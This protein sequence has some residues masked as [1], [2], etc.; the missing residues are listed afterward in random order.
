M[1]IWYRVAKFGSY[2]SIYVLWFYKKLI[3]IQA[4][5]RWNKI[6][7]T[8][9]L[10]TRISKI[11][12]G[13]PLTLSCMFLRVKPIWTFYLVV[14][15]LTCSTKIG[16]QQ[17]LMTPQYKNSK[18]SLQLLIKTL[19]VVVFPCICFITFFSG[20]QKINVFSSLFNV[21]VCIR[22]I[23]I[24]DYSYYFYVPQGMWNST[25]IYPC[26]SQNYSMLTQLLVIDWLINMY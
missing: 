25:Q 22:W 2:R 6:L 23:K 8:C 12:S 17:P 1:Y 4:T 9:T 26:I 21:F 15:L 13:L 7:N 19:Y 10:Y 20:D 14:I 3:D 5:I 24:T 16:V 18:F 11:G